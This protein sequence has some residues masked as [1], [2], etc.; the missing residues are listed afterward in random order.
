[1]DS[2][3]WYMTDVRWEI[4]ESAALQLLKYKCT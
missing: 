2:V 4:W 1:M 3:I